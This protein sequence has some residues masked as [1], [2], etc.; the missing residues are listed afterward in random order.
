ML[1]QDIEDV[2][3]QFNEKLL[4]NLTLFTD[5]PE[6]AE[7]AL[8]EAF[9]FAILNPP[10]LGLSYKWLYAKAINC[11]ID[12][13]HK[14]VEHEQ[15]IVEEKH[16]GVLIDHSAS[17]CRRLR[18]VENLVDTERALRALPQ[19]LRDVAE[20]KLQGYELHDI[21]CELRRPYETIRARWN[22][23]KDILRTKLRA[24]QKVVKHPQTPSGRFSRVAKFIEPY[25]YERRPC[26]TPI[27]R[28]SHGR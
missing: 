23:A 7:D 14:D 18:D 26:V 11:A 1:Q 19:R 3:L 9:E 6:L 16:D 12:R 21:A 2:Y 28:A 13:W 10:P 24:T 22:V 27:G 20:R 4:Y 15:P 5:D 8:H 17:E 25:A